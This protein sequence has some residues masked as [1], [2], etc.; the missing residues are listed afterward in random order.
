M[1]FNGVLM[2]SQ[3]VKLAVQTYQNMRIQ[4]PDIVKMIQLTSCCAM[5]SPP[6]LRPR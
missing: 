1:A 6:M 5:F 4:E 3:R 2:K